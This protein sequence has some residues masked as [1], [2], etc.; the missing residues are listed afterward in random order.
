MKNYIVGI[1]AALWDMFPEGKKMGGAPANFAY[2][3]SQ[4]GLDSCAVSAIGN[5][6]LGREIVEEMEKAGLN[7]SLPV[8]GYP[9]GT[10]QVELDSKGDPSYVISEN[11]AWDNIPCTEEL[12]EMASSCR[13]VCYGSLAQRNSI[14]R[15]T[16][17]TFLDAMP[18]DS[19]K[20]FDINIRQHFWSEEV[21]TSSLKR[22]DILKIN[23]HEI[24]QVAQ[25]YGLA[26]MT[27][28]EQ[29]RALMTE[30]SLKL[31][32]LTCGE[33]GSYVFSQEDVSY[34]DTPKVEVASAVG[35]GD[36]FTGAFVAA[37]LG[38]AGIKAA[39]ELAVE[40]SAY[41]CTQTGAMPELPET[42]KELRK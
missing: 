8:V 40:V 33:V 12:L 25:I 24:V 42:L 29:C 19:L 39:H 7:Y 6:E 18:E 28:E 38:G 35:A 32:I 14:S 41:V 23:E 17:E 10:V 9:T 27:I 22:A 5:D 4:F 3:V 1:G 21:V 31:V 2:H 13:A 26:D 37:Y 11:V 30:F 36:S 34:K 16:I 20:I 15:H